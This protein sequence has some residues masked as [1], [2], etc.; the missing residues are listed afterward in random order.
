MN[1]ICL[2]IDDCIFINDSTYAGEAEDALDLLEINLKRL[3]LIINKWDF[4]VF[5]TSS[6]FSI[7]ILEENN[8]LYNNPSYGL[9]NKSY[10]DL[11]FKAFNILS[12]YLNGYVIGLSCGDRFRDIEN[13][14]KEGHNIVA[15]D[16][17]DLSEIKDDNYIFLKTNGFIDNKSIYKIKQFIEKN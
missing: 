1:I 2:D 9:P 4:K 8:I 14:L 13:L 12:K 7:L 10:Y 5:I 3:L 17:M 15:I 11:E 16:D 6:W